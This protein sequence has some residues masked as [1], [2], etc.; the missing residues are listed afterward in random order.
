MLDKPNSQKKLPS[1]H[2]NTIKWSGYFASEELAQKSLDEKL[3]HVAEVEHKLVV[4]AKKELQNAKCHDLL[5]Y[6]FV[7][8]LNDKNEK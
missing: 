6:K 4:S 8:I 7:V 1:P 2:T 3:A 5:L